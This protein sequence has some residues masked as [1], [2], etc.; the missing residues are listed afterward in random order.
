M[1]FQNHQTTQEFPQHMC[2]KI[3]QVKKG[4]SSVATTLTDKG[5][6]TM[7][8]ASILV[9]V[10]TSEDSTPTAGGIRPS[11]GPYTSGRDTSDNAHGISGS[12]IGSVITCA[13][14]KIT[15]FSS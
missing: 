11:K 4:S 7:L 13:G 14:G 12:L 1:P 2:L 6:N 3:P 15:S 8:Q 5:R 10:L 9:Y